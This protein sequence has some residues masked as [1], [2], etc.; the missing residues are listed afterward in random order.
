MI[1]GKRG[2]GHRHRYRHR[3]RRNYSVSSASS[4]KT[5]RNQIDKAG[6]LFGTIAIYR[7][8]IGSVVFIIICIGVLIFANLY[9]KNWKETEALV[10]EGPT[11]HDVRNNKGNVSSKCNYTLEI[12]AEGMTKEALLNNVDLQTP[13]YR[14]NQTYIL[15]DYNINNIHDVAT[16]FKD[17]KKILN[18]IFGVLLAITLINLFVT[19]KYRNNRIMKGFKGIGL[20][21]NIIVPNR[22][23]GLMNVFTR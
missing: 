3:Q 22:Q 17:V 8:I 4:P 21:Q 1:G 16:P 18:W 15:V 10:K 5:K 7:S 9:H 23:P 13:I 14:N 12:S 2:H 19:Y 11:C 6:S 20:A